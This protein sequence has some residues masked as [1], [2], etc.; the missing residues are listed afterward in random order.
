MNFDEKSHKALTLSTFL[1]T[2]VDCAIDVNSTY[3]LVAREVFYNNAWLLHFT[4]L[5]LNL[6]EMC[7]LIIIKAGIRYRFLR[8]MMS[9][10]EG[11][12]LF[13]IN[14]FFKFTSSEP[15]RFY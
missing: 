15:Y 12:D 9:I 1:N 8:A 14:F 7:N 10:L 11:L 3:A 5:D 6:Y 4:F 2:Y 13:K